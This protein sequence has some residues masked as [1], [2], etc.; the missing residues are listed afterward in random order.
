MGGSGA[1]TDNFILTCRFQAVPDS[2]RRIRKGPRFQT[3][4][5]VVFK[6]YYREETSITLRLSHS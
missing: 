3:A 1:K 2:F 4:P 6:L 5:P